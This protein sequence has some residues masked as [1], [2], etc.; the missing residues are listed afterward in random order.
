VK[1]LTSRARPGRLVQNA[2]AL[3][4]SSGGTAVVGVVFW[5]FATHLTSPKSVGRTTAEI[6]AMAL[7]AN[8][9]QLS[10]G[11]IFERFL[12][13][14][15]ELTRNFVKRAYLICVAFGLL[16]S[17]AYL[18]SGLGH[19]FLPS[20]IGW[21]A[22][23]V[24]AVVLWTIFVLQDS[25]MIG[26]R[27]TKWVAVENIFFAL[28]K[29]AL[30]PLC[31]LISPSEGIFVAWTAPVIVTIIAVTWYLFRR[32]IPEHM[33]LSGPAEA[34]PSTRDLVALAG[35]QYASLLTSVFMPSLISLI[36]IQR[37]GPVANAHYFLPAMIATS[38]GLFYWSIARSF[39]VEASHEPQ[40]LRRH[41]NSAVRALVA[42]LVPCV[43]VG[44]IFTPDFLRIFGASYEARGSTLMR[45]L[46]LSLLGNAVMVFYS[47]FAWLD[48]SV[49]WMTV[50]NLG[51]S[52]VEVVLILLLIGHFGINAIGIG[53]LVSSVLTVI[54]FLPPSIRRYRNTAVGSDPNLGGVP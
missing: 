40:A 38:L 11:S 25:V 19:S 14:A 39:L 51:I 27:A 41:A 37:L 53:A 18:A 33:S 16:L 31:I 22:L 7:L 44:C 9:A 32:R 5:G 34:L 17:V 3:M 24:S 8:L 36:V 43:I 15:G 26:L 35:A 50:Q 29:L 52:V 21:R 49:W 54:L 1:S 23:F 20:S 46:L 30:L 45:M 12:P 6:A 4:I 42:V 2:I 13:I 47:T 28:A 48:K 10:F